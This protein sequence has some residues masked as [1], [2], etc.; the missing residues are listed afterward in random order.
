MPEKQNGEIAERVEIGDVGDGG[1]G[2]G[3]L[4]DG[5]VVFVPRTLPGE[6]VDV[7]IVEEREN[8]VRGEVEQFHE[9]SDERIESDCPYYAECGGC[10]FWHVPYERET[11]LKFDA[12][13]DRIERVGGIEL[14]EEERVEAPED[15]RY[16]TRVRFHR[17]RVAEEGEASDWRVGFFGRGSH[18]LVGIDDCLVAAEAVNRARREVEPGVVDVG[19][20][21]LRV[22]T[23]DADSAVV[24]ITPGEEAPEE[25]PQSLLEFADGLDEIDAIRGVRFLGEHKEWVGGDGSVDGS[26]VLADSPIETIRLP[27]G[28]F[29]QANP[30]INRRL[31]AAVR[32]AVVEAG[33]ARV[34]ECFSGVGNLTFAIADEVEAVLAVEV[35][36]VAVEMGATMAQFAG[37]EDVAFLEADLGRGLSGVRAIA[38]FDYETVVLDPPRGGAAAVCEALVDS[39]ADTIVYVSCDPAALGRDLATLAE[40]GWRPTEVTLFDMFPRTAHAEVLTVLSR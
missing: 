2:V 7:R 11:Q 27:A 22:E 35:D 38:A 24:S 25:P 30:Q 19:N 20:A 28:L 10:Q 9:Q 13:I 31:V 37:Y 32:E 8:W 21:E 23:A 15:R 12:T 29:R 4:A 18:D 14:P 36:E 17:R 34:L 1:D 39:A 33:A 3:E 6:V 26:E 5:R 40:G 16:R